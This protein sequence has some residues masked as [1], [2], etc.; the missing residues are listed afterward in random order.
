M[1]LIPKFLSRHFLTAFKISAILLGTPAFAQTL[2]Y[3]TPNDID[4]ETYFSSTRILEDAFF[5]IDDDLRGIFRYPFEDPETT[6]LFLLGIGALVLADK[7]LTSYYQDKVEPVFDGFYLPPLNLGSAFSVFSRESQYLYAGIVGSYA[8]GVALNDEK[9]QTAA[10]LAAKAV[11]YSY[12]VSHVLLKSAIGRNRPVQ[13]LSTFDGD[14]GISQRTRLILAI[15][16]GWICYP[17]R[18]EPLCHRSTQ[19]SIFPSRA[20]MPEFTTITGFLTAW[21]AFYLP[22]ISGAIGTGFQTWLPPL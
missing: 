22:P 1:N 16:T 14:P 11:A 21:R 6:S 17:T 10:I 15:I 19:H 9:S 5:T 18:T 3:S 13:N 12:L 20:S 4:Q 8:V 2:Q 7:P